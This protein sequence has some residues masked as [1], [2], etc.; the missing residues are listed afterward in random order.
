MGNDE[1][2]IS[3]NAVDDEGTTETE[4]RTLLKRLRDSGF[5][6]NDEKL[7]VAL[8][9]PIEEIQGW[10]G[11]AEPVDDDVVMKAR[12]IAKERGIQIE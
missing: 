8:G 9:R 7:A 11:G 1:R 5:E 10:M 3:T 6:G 12:G 2:K 4:G